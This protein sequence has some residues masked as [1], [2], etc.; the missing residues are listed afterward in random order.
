[1]LHDAVQA[2]TV[3]YLSRHKLKQEEVAQAA[4]QDYDGRPSNSS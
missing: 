1:M 4:M 2:D 3:L